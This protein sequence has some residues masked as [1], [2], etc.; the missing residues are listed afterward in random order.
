VDVKRAVRADLATADPGAAGAANHEGASAVG[1]VARAFDLGHGA[2]L[3]EA[4][5]DLRNENE[6][7][8]GLAC[9]RRGLLG[10]VGFERDRDHHLGEHDS[11]RQ[12]E[13]GKKLGLRL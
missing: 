4:A 9:R 7:V 6:L 8:T 13:Q 10:L 11:L 5:L 2:H 3:G 1:Q 12:W